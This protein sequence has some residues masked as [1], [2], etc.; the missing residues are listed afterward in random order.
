MVE[1]LKWLGYTKFT[2]KS[3]NEPAIVKLL[4]GSPRELRINGVSRVFDEHPPE[5][6]PQAN[7]AAEVDVKLLKNTYGHLG[8]ISRMRLVIE[9]PQKFRTCCEQI[10]F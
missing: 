2:L 9:F 5:Y 7:P 8:A 3:D 4:S 1:D 10:L 6:G